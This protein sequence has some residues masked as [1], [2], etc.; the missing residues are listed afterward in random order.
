MR[1]Q[2]YLRPC[3]GLSQWAPSERDVAPQVKATAVRMVESAAAWDDGGGTPASARRRLKQAGYDPTLADDLGPLL[4]GGET[5]AAQV[6]VA[7]YGGILT[8]TASV[9]VVVDQ[10]TLD[11][12]GSVRAGGTTL[13]IRLQADEPQ[14]TVTEVRPA[15]LGGYAVEP[16]RLARQLLE[17]D[18]VVLPFAAVADV[19]SGAIDPFGTPGADTAVSGLS[20]GREHPSFRSSAARLRHRSD[21]QPHGGARGRHLGHRW[22][23]DH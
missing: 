12:S 3:R 13:D 2:P 6:V 22:A 10:W 4:A 17:N 21:E 1:R 23:S 16:S 8:D 11:E 18:R 20:A 5:A 15:R 7:Q 14:W 9:L 19:R